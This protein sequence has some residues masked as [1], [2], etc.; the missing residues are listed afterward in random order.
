[1]TNT[2]NCVVLNTEA[3][4]LDKVPHPGELG[5]RIFTNVSKEGWKRWLQ[6]A[7]VII[8]EN[9]LNTSDEKHVALLEEQMLGFF[10]KEGNYLSAGLKVPPPQ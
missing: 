7:T 3:E 9:G 10:F 1:M 5:Q 2:V 6:H 8:N 4:A